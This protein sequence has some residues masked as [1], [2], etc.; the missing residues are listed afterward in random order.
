MQLWQIQI[1]VFFLTIIK[2]LNFY[3]RYS[4][5]HYVDFGALSCIYTHSFIHGG[6]KNVPVSIVETVSKLKS[7]RNET[8]KS[9]TTYSCFKSP[10]I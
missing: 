7:P 8:H 4:C 5:Y 1:A 2:W 3:Y 6:P 10:T 9:K